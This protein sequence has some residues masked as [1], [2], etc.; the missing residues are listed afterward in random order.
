MAGGFDSGH[1][2]GHTALVGEAVLRVMPA[3]PFPLFTKYI[4]CPSTV[5]SLVFKE[6]SARYTT[7]GPR[8]TSAFRI[9][10]IPVFCKKASNDRNNISR[11]IPGSVSRQRFPDTPAEGDR[12][13]N[14]S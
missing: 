2:D 1:R 11:G 3:V 8:K 10:P 9:Y 14:V 7:K 4:F 6:F 13:A 5:P 12:C